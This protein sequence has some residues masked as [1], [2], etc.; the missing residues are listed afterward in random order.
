M[1]TIRWRG[2][3]KDHAQLCWYEG[4]VEQRVTLGRI[5]PSEAER[6]RKTKDLELVTGEPI[7]LGSVRFVDHR[8][9]YLKW[10]AME[11]PDSHFRVEQILRDCCEP[12]ESKSLGQIKRKDIEFWK[13]ARMTRIGFNRQK[14]EAQVSRGT[15]A[16][17][18]SVVR[19]LF[20]KAVDWEHIRKSPFEDVPEPK[21]LNDA[22]PHWYHKHE[23]AQ[24]Y[25]RTRYGDTWK[26]MANTGV[27]LSEALQL[28]PKDVDLERNVLRVLSKA[29]ARTKSGKWRQIPLNDAAIDALSRLIPAN[30]GWVIR[31]VRGPSLSRAFLKDARALKLDGSAHSLRHSYGTHMA[32]ARIPLRVLKEHMGHRR[33]ETTMIYLHIVE[34]MAHAEARAVNL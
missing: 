12:F 1:A 15:A 3:K 30:E 18:F 7:F 8:E 2:K 20:T 33:I 10:H 17:E 23:L 34:A 11:Y 32:M 31:H 13:G 24:L 21:D 5:P 29:D 6:H 22:P 26:L 14:E 19:A 25:Q 28:Q 16:K 4:G 9:E 27:R